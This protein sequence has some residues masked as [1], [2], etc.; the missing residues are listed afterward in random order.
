MK[1][2][3][4]QW[5]GDSVPKSR[6]HREQRN[7]RLALVSS[8]VQCQLAEYWNVAASREINGLSVAGNEA[9]LKRMTISELTLFIAFD[10]MVCSG[11]LLGRTARWFARRRCFAGRSSSE[12]S[13]CEEKFILRS[14]SQVA[15]PPLGFLC[16]ESSTLHRPVHRESVESGEAL[17]RM[18]HAA[19]IQ[20]TQDVQCR[21]H[22]QTVILRRYSR[23]VVP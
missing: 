18:I 14:S 3:L 12:L 10:W 20:R 22:T 17:C 13:F 5:E 6:C 9:F 8:S 2:N 11:F 16:A 21:I 1:G 19:K 7:L 23:Y 15:L 4:F